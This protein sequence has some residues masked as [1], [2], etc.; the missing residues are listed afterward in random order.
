MIILLSPINLEVKDLT[1]L[2]RNLYSGE[3]ATLK[4]R[5]GTTLSRFSHVRLFA[6]LW[7]R[8]PPGSSVHGILQARILEWVVM[9][10]SQPR[11]RTCLLS[12]M[13]P[14]LAGEFFTTRYQSVQFSSVTSHVRLFATPWTAACQA[15]LSITNSQNL[16]KFMSIE[17][18]MS[19]N[20][21]TL[22]CHLL[23]PSVFPSIRVFSSESVP[24][25][26]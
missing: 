16:L 8:I 7:T 25:I 20:H 26:R 3:E 22:R 19:S 6:A 13:S 24:L 17:S 18:V 23:P 15:S 2:L 21:V 12:L 10:F 11:D 1:C 9:P 14:T 5:H 4:T